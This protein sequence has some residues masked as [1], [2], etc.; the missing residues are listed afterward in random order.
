MGNAIKI[1]SPVALET[2]KGI[3]RWQKKNV[4]VRLGIPN[5]TNVFVFDPTEKWHDVHIVYNSIIRKAFWCYLMQEFGMERRLV[6]VTSA[7]ITQ[8]TK[9]G[10]TFAQT[11]RYMRVR[12]TEYIVIKFDTH[13]RKVVG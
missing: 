9:D 13:F 1:G 11:N 7:P 8:S 4:V 6:N 3:N 5:K 2:G 12:V 10:S